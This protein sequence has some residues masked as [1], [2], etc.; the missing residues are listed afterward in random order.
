MN[1][2]NLVSLLFSSISVFRAMVVALWEYHYTFFYGSNRKKC[3][4]VKIKIIYQTKLLKCT[5]LYA[6]VNPKTYEFI[7][8]FSSCENL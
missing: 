8:P 6:N 3:S 7:F 1:I 5:Q 2:H 4:Q